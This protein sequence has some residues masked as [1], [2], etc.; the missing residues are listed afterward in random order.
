MMK[1]Q[2]AIAEA[3]PSKLTNIAY[4]LLALSPIFVILLPW[5][6][7]PEYSIYRAV[8]AG[9]SLTVP[10]I[11]LVMILFLMRNESSVISAIKSLSLP[12]KS[13]L[14][15]LVAAV[16]YTTAFVAEFKF[17]AVAGILFFFIHAMVCVDIAMHIG[18]VNKSILERFWIV[19]GL[20]TFGYAALW[21][22]GYAVFPPS[23][24]D[25]IHR[26]PGVTN[27]R[28]T[29]FFWLGIFAA[30]F[31]FA[32]SSRLKPNISAIIFGSFGLGM[33]L[34]TGSRGALL[35]CLVAAIITPII[36]AQHRKFAI[37]YVLLTTTI[38]VGV[39]IFL[40]I[41]NT[42]YGIERIYSR[43]TVFDHREVS[44][45]RLEL[46]QSTAEK[47]GKKPM[48]G[49]GIDQF[50][51][52]GPEK[53]LGFKGAHSGPLQIL[54]SI[55]IIGALALLYG[56][57]R[58]LYLYRIKVQQPHQLAALAFFGGGSI[59]LLYDNFIY[60]TFP[61]AIFSISI[62]MVFERKKIDAVSN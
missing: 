3:S 46:W 43:S 28:W 18:S 26:V 2:D 17:G 44:S 11:E 9:H 10:I 37:K 29:G 7:G 32:R 39:N 45:G 13:V 1:S 25:W 48:L 61:I 16:I 23:E 62:L 30:G 50:Q 42:L 57:I 12:D 31:V 56:V 35:A 19:L 34:W 33:V 58:F 20:A 47:V 21:A 14:L 54:F 52:S 6:F 59:Y 8:I 22:I 49:Y 40:P 38:A 41:P 53:T 51:V 24:T 15:V 5:D 36:A 60:Y 27:V 4:I 55:G